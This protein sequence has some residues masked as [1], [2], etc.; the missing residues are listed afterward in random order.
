M[1]RP[2]PLLAEAGLAPERLRLV[3]LGIGHGQAFA[4]ASRDDAEHPALGP[5]SARSRP[6]PRKEAVMK[7]DHCEFPDDL[8][9]TPEHVWARVE[10]D[11]SPSGSPSSARTWPGKIVFVEVPRVGPS[12]DQ[13]RAV[14]VHGVRA[15]G[16]GGSSPPWAGRSSEAN[17]ELEWESDAGQQRPVRQGLAGEDQARRPAGPLRPAEARLARVRRAHRGGAGQVR[18]VAKPRGNRD[19]AVRPRARALAGLAAA[20]PRPAAGGRGGL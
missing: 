12:R 9:Y 8:Y 16:S 13:G 14:H 20:L 2:G 19:E 1:A 5:V 11:T 10:G 18:Q 15:S 4:E 3:H 17:E 7:I 6:C